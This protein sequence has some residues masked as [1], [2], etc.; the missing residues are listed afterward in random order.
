[1]QV[2]IAS[3]QLASTCALPTQAEFVAVTKIE[4]PIEQ[5]KLQS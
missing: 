3:A 5:A 2:A 1:V 4:S